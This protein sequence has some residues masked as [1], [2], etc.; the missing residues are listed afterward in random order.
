MFSQKCSV[1]G[2][3]INGRKWKAMNGSQAPRRIGRS[4]LAVV[5]GIV[6][7]VAVTLATDVLL[8]AMHILPPLDQRV[9]DGLLLLAMAYRTVYS[10]AASYLIARLAPSSPMM[11]ALTGGFIGLVVNFAGTVATWNAGPQYQS[12]WYPIAL[13]VLALPC[14]WVGGLLWEKQMESQPS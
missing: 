5:I 10:V 13:T 4:I 11:H 2:N 1:I 3:E 7:G 9:S 6:A 14:A 12:H 8:R